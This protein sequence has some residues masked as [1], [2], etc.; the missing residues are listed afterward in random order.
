MS[1]TRAFYR[2]NK[3]DFIV[4]LDDIDALEQYKTDTTVPLSQVVGNFDVYKSFTGGS[5][6]MLEKASNQELSEEF[7][8]FNSVVDDI[9]P[10]IIKNGQIQ[11]HQKLSKGRK[12]VDG[13][14]N[15]EKMSSTAQSMG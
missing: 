7:G 8:D 5:S 9:I 11:N 12:S 2:G 13:G 15:K 6:G 3:E 1:Q 4:F 10:K 14:M